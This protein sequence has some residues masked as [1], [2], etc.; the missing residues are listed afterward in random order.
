MPE[1][2]DGN[3]FLLVGGDP[4]LDLLN[5]TPVL[6]SGPVDLLPDFAA[7]TRWLAA[8]GLVSA[9][10]QAQWRRRWSARREG[11]RALAQVKRLRQ[12]LL[13][14]LTAVTRGEAIREE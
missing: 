9:P 4:A 11:A 1:S 12:D 5:T 6:A 14:I 13:A 10:Q 3:E 8:T 7:L 2:L